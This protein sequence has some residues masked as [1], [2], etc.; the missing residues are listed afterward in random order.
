MKKGIQIAIGLGLMAFFIWIYVNLPAIL[1]W[2]NVEVE[3]LII[4]LVLINIIVYLLRTVLIR[5]NNYLFRGKMIQYILTILINI[6]WAV[7][8]F[9]LLIV[10]NP[11][12]AT[13]IVSF[14]IV[15][16][17]LTF[18]DR[19]N[20]I[21]SGVL[22]LFSGS[23]EVGD[24]VEIKGIQGIV[25]EITLNYT[26][27]RGID[28]LY[29]YVTN[30]QVYNSAVKKFTHSKDLELVY[31]QQKTRDKNKGAIK[32]Y[33][34]NISE[35]ISKEERITRYIKIIELLSI[36]D[37][38]VI[39]ESL[40]KIFTKYEE[41]FGIRPFYYINNT[42]LDRCS[43]TIQIVTK[44]PNLIPYYISSLLRDLIYELYDEIIYHKWEGEKSVVPPSTEEVK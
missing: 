15:A 29:R 23:F 28:G 25:T 5:I 27:I 36:N 1:D 2:F 34:S 22:L 8:V 32:K 30:T 9:W 35:L 6:I 43:I 19:I 33:V 14:L 16:I 21:V 24:F 42:T 12:M 7:F 31:E 17:A 41:I 11:F 37:P 10:I 44:K 3:A 20:N 13:G 40:S 38:R 26:K 39:D 18:T 4:D